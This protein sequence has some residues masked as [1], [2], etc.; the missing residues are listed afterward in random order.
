[1]ILAV[2]LLVVGCS[3]GAPAATPSPAPPTAQATPTTAPTAAPTSAP[4]AAPTSPSSSGCDSGYGYGCD[5]PGPTAGTTAAPTSAG[6]ELVVVVSSGQSPY[7]VG[8]TG[9]SLYV[10]ANDSPGVS[11]CTGG[12]AGNWPALTAAT[13]QSVA[14]AA[15]ASG[16]FA[17][18]TRAD[19]SLQVTY[20]DA[21]LYYF[22]GD[23]APGDT[24][25][26]GIG[27]VWSLARP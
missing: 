10:F 3:Y 17:T 7:L 18:I 22:A 26:D 23:S 5:T 15:G 1:M 20:N 16:T 6:G 25:G 14:G 24:N 11:T 12:C 9:L 2:L 8:P 27:G 13:G 21:P 19:G 4:T